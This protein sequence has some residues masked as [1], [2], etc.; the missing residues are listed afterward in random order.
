MT[1][2][3]REDDLLAALPTLSRRFGLGAV[4]DQHF[5][6]HGLMNR[7]WRL[8]T[9]AGTYAVKEITDVPLPKVRRNLA[10]LVDLAREEIPV[11]APLTADGGD[12]V[13]EVGGHGYC[14]LP[15][16]VGEH[17][18]GTDLTLDQARD[19]GALLARLHEGLGR[20]GPGP[21]PEQ[22][23]ATKVRDVAEADEAAAVLMSRLLADPVTDFD[24][25]AT[26]ALHERR[27]LL[28]RHTDGQPE[29]EVPTGPYG[30]T[31]GDFQYRNLLRRDGRVVAVLDWDRLGVR[32]YGE[33][34]A[35]TAQVQFG[36][37]GVFDLDRIAAF[38]AGYRSVIDLPE[39]DLADAVKRLWWKRLTDFWQLEFYL[40]RQDPTFGE[41]FLTDEALLNWWTDRADEVQTA[42]AAR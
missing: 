20:H 14:I 7:N 1:D 38:C 21:V 11:P 12:L 9:E 28:A 40:D 31:H 3:T 42:Y 18:Q 4:R 29:S 17:V 19:L 27:G 13:V 32:P 26:E 2:T 25:V 30:W 37:G 16:A 22:A 35:R 15:W 6:T 5:L 39:G 8:E 33:E 10:V 24:K 41:M 36:V 34:V 23:P